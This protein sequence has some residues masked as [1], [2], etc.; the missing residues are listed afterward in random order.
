[1]PFH[2]FFYAQ[3]F[4]IHLHDIGVDTRTTT[5]RNEELSSRVGSL[6]ALPT[7]RLQYVEKG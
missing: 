1:M 4:L 7:Q 2:F 5:R 3:F 6:F